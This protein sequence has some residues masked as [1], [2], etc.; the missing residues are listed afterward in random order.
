MAEVVLKNITKR[1]DK[2]I[3]VSN[4]NLEIA[5]GEFMVFVGPSGCGKTTTLR[6]IAGLE[7]ITEGEVYIG[8]QLVNNL[9][10]KDRNIAMVFQNYAIYPHMKVSGNLAFGLKMRKVPKQK[11]DQAV[12]EAA[13][14]LGIQDL[15]DRKPSQLSGGQRQRVALGRAIVRK[16]EVFLF[17]EPLSNLDAKLRVQMRTELKK[18][19]ERLGT[20]A[21][22]VT[23]D[24]VEAMTM[25]DRIMAMNDGEVQQVGS[26]LELYNRPANLFVAGFIGSPAMNFIPCR[27]VEEGSSLSIDT[28]DFEITLPDPIVS[29]ARAAKDR[30]P[31]LGIR[32]EDLREILPGQTP[33]IDKLTIRAKV[34]VIEPLGKEISLDI[35]TGAH[36]MTALLGADTKAKPHHNIDLVVNMQKIHLFAKKGGEAII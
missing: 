8:D 12:R 33:S 3:V 16:P 18:L 28:G 35:T 24:Q 7:E 36:S 14:I 9:P 27:L 15:L 4:V 2:A 30:E 34:N 19:H 32:P 11:W 13:E 5:D 26:P 20:T 21:I 22:Y 29:K 1:F 10:P 23:H 25:G 31:I 6:M 17:D